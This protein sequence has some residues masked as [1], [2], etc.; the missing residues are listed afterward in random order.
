MPVQPGPLSNPRKDLNQG[1][2]PL[3]KNTNGEPR[4]VRVARRPNGEIEIRHVPRIG[5]HKAHL[6]VLTPQDAERLAELLTTAAGR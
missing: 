6:I 1:S 2:E 3:I 4:V 5:D